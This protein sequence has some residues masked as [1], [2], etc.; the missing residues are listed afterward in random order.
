MA[1]DKYS[2]LLKAGQLVPTQLP[3]AGLSVISTQAGEVYI[4]GSGASRTLNLPKAK[5]G[6]GPFYIAVNAAGSPIVVQP[7]TADTIRGAAAGASVTYNAAG[8][9]VEFVCFYSGTWEPLLL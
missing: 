1:T 6:A 8:Q 9:V 7:L 3:P 4:N 5:P 2:S